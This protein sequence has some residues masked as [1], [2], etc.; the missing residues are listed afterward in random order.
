MTSELLQSFENNR[1]CL[2]LSVVLFG[3]DVLLLKSRCLGIDVCNCAP[4]SKK[5]EVFF[6]NENFYLSL[7][8]LTG[9]LTS[10]SSCL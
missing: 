9:E 1:A 6:E 5:K 3:L 4:V 8:G 10:Y 2:S 7:K